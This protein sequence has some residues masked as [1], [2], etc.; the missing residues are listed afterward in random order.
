[1]GRVGV[2]DAPGS[3]TA[4][5]PAEAKRR[6]GTQAF[7]LGATPPAIRRLGPGFGYAARDD[8]DKPPASGREVPQG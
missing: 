3:C 6:A 7:N 8:G 2:K 1:M 5:I 4:V